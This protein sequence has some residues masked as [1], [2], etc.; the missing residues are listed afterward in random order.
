VSEDDYY[1]LDHRPTLIENGDLLV[2]D[3][4]NMPYVAT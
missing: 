1:K 4:E 3:V 2:V